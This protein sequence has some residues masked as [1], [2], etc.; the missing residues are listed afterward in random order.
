MS[1]KME[2]FPGEGR[3]YK[4]NLHC[5]TVISDGALTPEETRKAYAERGYDVVAFSDHNVLV[6]HQDL[7]DGGFLALNALEIDLNQDPRNAPPGC[8]VKVYHINF[9]AKDPACSVFPK[10]DRIY[11]FAAA[12][13]LID[14]AVSAGFLVQFNHP[15]WSMQGNDEYAGLKGLS[16]FE[17]YNH[18]CQ[19]SMNDG[20]GNYEYEYY[21]REGG[22][23]A[24]TA[25]DDNHCADRNFDSPYNDCFGGWTMIKADRLD[26][27]SV[28]GALASKNFYATTG[29]LI[30]DGGYERLENGSVRVYG[31]TSP[32]RAVYVR[33]N[34]RYTACVLS[35][36]NDVGSFDLTLDGGIRWFRL[37][38]VDDRGNMAV[39]R[40]YGTADLKY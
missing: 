27:A 29:P 16:C 7:T 18:G 11:G 17:V 6:D 19:V 13:E 30:F 1:R 25:T 20:W 40:A 9:I 14:K 26:Y 5:H 31:R 23:A 3:F 35:K 21:V 39:S 10:F 32:C 37:E 2:L 28:T 38:I 15:R 36:Q 4:A 24:P 34:T 8:D 12:Q 33:T 22:D